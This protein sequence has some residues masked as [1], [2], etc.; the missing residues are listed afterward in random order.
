MSA[1]P[2]HDYCRSF[3]FE[4]LDIRGAFVQLNEAWRQMLA[5]RGYPPPV[6]RLLG[7]LTAVTVLIAANLKQPG[8]MTFQLSGTGPVS[9]L[10]LDCDQQL[11]LKGMA[12][13]TDP[14]APAPVPDLL[15]HGRLALTLDVAGMRQPYQSLVPLDGDSIAAIFEHY[16]ARSEQQP[17]LLALAA[18]EQA[19]SGLFLQKLPGADAR[20]PDGWNRLS[21]LARTL[22]PD[23]L[24]RL[25]TIQLLTRLFPEEDIRVYDPRPVR[26]HCP[27]DWDKVRHMLR[28]LGRSECEAILHE[29]G[30]IHI[31]DE[32]CNQD[33]VLDAG[34]VAALFAP[35]DG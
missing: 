9:L 23:E 1:P 29:Q 28:S 5:G 26:Y 8:R 31:H 20:D 24:L 33:Y 30:Q 10:L 15:G 19:A 35:G 25:P 16:L 32:V 4:R 7:E 17:A 34:E 11:R 3:L 27:R 2:V 21:L 22:Q 12:R 13:C 18:S 14:V 6:V